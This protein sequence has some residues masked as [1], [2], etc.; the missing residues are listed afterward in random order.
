MFTQSAAWYDR[1]YDGKDYAREAQRVA[2]LIR[3][4]QPHARSLLDVACGTGRHL[5]HLRQEFACQGL[6]LDGGLLT[7]ARER[8]PGIKLT[9]ADMAEF[10]L[11]RRFDA[12]TC[13]FSSVGYLGTV[14]RLGA[15]VAAMAGHLEPGGVLVVE[16]W[17]LPEAWIEGGK[18]SVEVVDD[19]DRKLVRVMV[20]SR[21]GAMSIL[22]LHYVVAANGTIAT[23]DERHELR[24]F[25]QDEYLDAFAAAG[26]AATWDPDGLT[27]RGLLLGVG[28][29]QPRTRPGL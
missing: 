27:G 10:D 29:S 8:L 16:P 20:S 2:A 1:F 24:L 25:T 3:Q 7:I 19:E 17:I 13:L 11:G 22:R 28:Q 23:A 4:H 14:Q 15:A 6:D 26:L 9:Q 12:V 21:E 5:Q 18:N